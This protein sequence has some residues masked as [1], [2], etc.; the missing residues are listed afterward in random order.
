[1]DPIDITGVLLLLEFS[2]PLVRTKK[3]KFESAVA[4]YVLVL[5]MRLHEFW[6]R[7]QVVTVMFDDVMKRFELPFS[8]RMLVD[9]REATLDRPLE[10]DESARFILDAYADTVNEPVVAVS[11][12]LESA[13]TE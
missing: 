11:E 7:L 4:L 1:L 10:L 2:V 8:F 6:T 3:L 9:D 12:A 5:T 13:T